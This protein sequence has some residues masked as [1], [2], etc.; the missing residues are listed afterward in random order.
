MPLVVA[1][2]SYV[3]VLTS[4]AGKGNLIWKQGLCRCDEGKDER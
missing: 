4:K 1:L 3:H 2:E